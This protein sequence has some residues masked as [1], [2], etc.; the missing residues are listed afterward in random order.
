MIWLL[1]IVVGGIGLLAVTAPEFLRKGMLRVTRATMGRLARYTP[2]EQLLERCPSAARA[3]FRFLGLG[4]L[5]IAFLWGAALLGYLA[6]VAW[7]FR[8]IVR[9]VVGT[10]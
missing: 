3:M 5:T 4:F 2:G 6:P 7:F 10:P 9:P 1:S 8:N